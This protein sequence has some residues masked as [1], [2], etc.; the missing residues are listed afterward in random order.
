M[1]DGLMGSPVGV[2]PIPLTEEALDFIVSYLRDCVTADREGG[3][4]HGWYAARWDMARLYVHCHVEC[5]EGEAAH[6]RGIERMR[7][8]VAVLADP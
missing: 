4:A 2:E 3:Y 1:D 6:C 7:G 5:G 8:E